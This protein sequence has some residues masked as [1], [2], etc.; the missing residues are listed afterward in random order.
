MARSMQQLQAT[1]STA[2]AARGTAQTM[3][4]MMASY[5]CVLE[6]AAELDAWARLE[7]SAWADLGASFLSV[8]AGTLLAGPAQQAP[9]RVALLFLGARPGKP[10][11]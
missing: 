1:T 7:M 8:G 4:Q 9:P 6:G 5:T 2:I 10:P 3:P 11:T